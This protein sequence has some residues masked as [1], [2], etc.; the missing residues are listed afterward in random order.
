MRLNIFRSIAL[1]T[2]G[3]TIFV[4]VCCYSGVLVYSTY[5]KC[6]PITSGM[7]KV[8]FSDNPFGSELILIYAVHTILG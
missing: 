6:D 3:M 1:F 2:I 8:F 4:S 5:W 7:I